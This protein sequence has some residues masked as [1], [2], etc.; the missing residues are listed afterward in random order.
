MVTVHVHTIHVV[1][2]TQ[3]LV[4]LQSGV[5]KHWAAIDNHIQSMK[6]SKKKANFFTLETVKPQSLDFCLIK[7][8]IKSSINQLFVKIVTKYFITCVFKRFLYI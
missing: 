5:E 7:L 6:M 8:S 3:R 2:V 4:A 1:V